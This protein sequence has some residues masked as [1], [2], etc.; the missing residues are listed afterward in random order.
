MDKEIEKLRSR[1]YEINQQLSN[2]VKPSPVATLEDIE[3]ERIANQRKA[4]LERVRGVIFDQINEREQALSRKEHK[5]AIETAKRQI[6]KAEEQLK[7]ICEELRGLADKQRELL[8]MA[9]GISKE[10]EAN[11]NLAYPSTRSLPMMVGAN[12]KHGIYYP[13]APIMQQSEG[14]TYTFYLKG[15]K[16]LG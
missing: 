15:E 9:I 4:D 13:T 3:N 1:L 12:P 5:K 8:G 6:S 2:I 11:M 7:A 14:E 16:L 10:Q